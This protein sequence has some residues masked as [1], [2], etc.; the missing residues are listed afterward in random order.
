MKK[1]LA[2]DFQMNKTLAYDIKPVAIQVPGNFAFT[3]YYY[4]EVTKNAEG[5]TDEHK[6]R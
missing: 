4:V 5:K 3:D 2:L 6:G 1:F